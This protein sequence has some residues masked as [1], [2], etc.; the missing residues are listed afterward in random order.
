MNERIQK[1]SA[2]EKKLEKIVKKPNISHNEPDKIAY[3]RDLDPRSIIKLR[4]GKYCPFPSI[5]VKP[6]NERQISRI[7]EV[8][9]AESV[10]VVP[11]GCG[12]GVCGGTAPL[13]GGVILDMKRMNR[14]ISLDK[15]SLIAKVQTGIIGEILERELQYRGFTLGHFP[16]SIYCSALG[17]WISARS[18]GQLSPR[19][20]KIEDMIVALRVVL[21]NGKIVETT[22]PE[23]FP[24]H[25]KNAGELFVGAEGTLGVITQATLKIYRKP[26]ARCFQGF[27]FK[28]LKDALNAIR[29]IMQSDVKP[30][31]VRL[32]DPFD[33]LL[34][35]KS[36][37]GKTPLTAQLLN[38]HLFK[39]LEFI[40]KSIYSRSEA[41]LLAHPTKLNLPA[42]II[43]DKCLLIM[44]FEG[45]DEISAHDLKAAT[46]ICEKNDGENAGSQPAE[47]WWNNR[48]HVS[49]NQSKIFDAGS[50]VDTIE[51][52][53]T[54]DKV[55]ALYHA[56]ISKVRKKAFIMAHF[57]H[58]YPEGC[59]IYFSVV[60]NENDAETA[61]K[62]HQWVWAQALD[63]FLEC[64]ATISHHHGI[65]F[66][67]QNWMPKEKGNGI[68]VLRSFK[69]VIDPGG[70]MNPG[71]MSL[72]PDNIDV[73][74]KTKKRKDTVRG[75]ETI[76][77]K[78][79]IIKD[80]AEIA[81]FVKKSLPFMTPEKADLPKCIMMP[82]NKNQ[83]AECISLLFGK[84]KKIYVVGNGT[85]TFF[86]P[87]ELS[88]AYIIRMTS[89]NRIFKPDPI[90]MTAEAESGAKIKD[91][92]EKLKEE[93]YRPAF[94]CNRY[95]EGTLGGL[96][97]ARMVYPDGLTE[98]S[99]ENS[100]LSWTG[101]LPDGS[102]LKT[103]NVPASA[104]GPDLK[105]LFIGSGG[106]FVLMTA[107][108]FKIR[109]IEKA[110]AS[111]IFQTSDA[112]KTLKA[113]AGLLAA[114]MTTLHCEMLF[115]D[116]GRKLLVQATSYGDRKRASIQLERFQK[117]MKNIGDRLSEVQIEKNS[118]L[119]NLKMNE[120]MI[121]VSG[122]WKDLLII[123][124]NDSF[125]NDV[126]GEPAMLSRCNKHGATLW[127]KMKKSALPS[128]EDIKKTAE[129]AGLS[130]LM[131]KRKGELLY[132]PEEKWTMA[133][134]ARRFLASIPAF[135]EI[136]YD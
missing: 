101:L 95:D 33:T 69:S 91:I 37:G 74:K 102:E 89:L 131:L 51:T 100:I 21:P 34:V 12:S 48:Y 66:L 87:G 113:I 133:K 125:F 23:L 55:E 134:E 68:N 47:N 65:G 26:A 115:D 72:N 58:P 73:P 45:N 128:D 57:S 114:D 126:C 118:E 35:G 38:T 20:G 70:L 132:Y 136:H 111:E 24:S 120:R 135:R 99:L 13:E 18:A 71:K 39:A 49:Y 109:R 94:A 36:S 124:S 83:L 11:F 122:I 46:D 63:A 108:R 31:A 130:L 14:I 110:A 93:G 50:F 32:Y 9:R 116:G 90:T 92:I 17:G 1:L 64:D 96:L 41:W 10:P 42:G 2:V 40:S 28:N 6:K 129:K 8:C 76:A 30:A 84:N 5:I 54:W 16:S 117:S 56:V 81:D 104:A 44:T 53:A 107:V 98:M 62:T 106:H 88:G 123:F 61:L 19:Y 82:E 4:A 60:G 78:K 67:K 79:G 59:S 25:E 43:P 127:I 75:L 7:L 119:F 121:S 112:R 85:R 77:G 3:S 105:P 27:Y 22:S 103:R 97:G 86:N 29:E 52:C 15:N 80:S